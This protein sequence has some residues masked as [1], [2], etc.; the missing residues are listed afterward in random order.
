MSHPSLADNDTRRLRKR[1]LIFAICCILT[2]VAHSQR[3]PLT[4]RVTDAAGKPIAS[5]LVGGFHKLQGGG[6]RTDRVETDSDGHY[7]LNDGGRVIF[8]RKLGFRPVTKLPS[9]T[10]SVLNVTLEEQES[11]W[12]LPRCT[13]GIEKVDKHYGDNLIFLVPPGTEVKEGTPD[14]DNWK[15]WLLFPEDHQP[16]LLIWSGG[17]LGGGIIYFPEESWFLDGSVISEK[18][19]PKHGAM[20]VRGKMPDGRNWRSLSFISDIAEYHGASDQA[21]RFFDE[22][23]DAA[24]LNMNP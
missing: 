14:D 15:V 8:F 12:I 20:D 3:M 1:G 4:G 21:A 10:D 23:L 2:S 7:R 19:D 17:L 13:P 18:S 16:R 24:C 5:V 6:Y 22:V 11:D 9:S